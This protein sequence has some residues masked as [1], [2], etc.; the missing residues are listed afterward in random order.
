MG[1]MCPKCESW[2]SIVK[3]HT[4]DGQPPEKGDDVIFVSLAC[5]HAFGKSE[6]NEYN[7]IVNNIKADTAERIRDIE[8]KSSAAISVAFASFLEKK[9]KKGAT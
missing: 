5:K 3:V 9:S 4:A 1:A 6:F 8:S 2:Q 7:K